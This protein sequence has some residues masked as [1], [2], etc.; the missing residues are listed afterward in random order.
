MVYWWSGF[1]LLLLYRAWLCFGL[2]SSNRVEGW[3]LAAIETM[4]I[5]LGVFN[6]VVARRR[7]YRAIGL[8]VPL[9]YAAGVVLLP[10]PGWRMASE[11]WFLF[12][13]AVGLSTW[14]LV[15]L[16][17]RFSIAGS[18]W[19]S[20]CE[21][22]PYAFVRHPQL[23]ARLV[24]VGSVAMSGVDWS[25]TAALVSCVALTFGVIDLEE[26]MLRDAMSWRRYAERVRYR[27]LPGVW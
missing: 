23:A 4:S 5:G 22:G 9:A 19:I 20:L 27:V 10:A 17:L 3:A 21:K 7:D 24:I 25:A 26:S 8:L 6:A 1:G 11:R 12:I 2:M 18:T 13:A 16:G 14:G 15:A